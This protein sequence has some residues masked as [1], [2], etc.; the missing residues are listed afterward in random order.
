MCKCLRL[1]LG[2]FGWK[3]EDSIMDLP[4]IEDV[5]EALTEV[6]TIEVS[7]PEATGTGRPQLR[8]A[9]IT[10]INTYQGSPLRGC[11]NDALLMYKVLSEKYDFKTENIDLLTDYD[12]TKANLLKH[13]KKLTYGVQPGD[14]VF[15]HYS[16]HG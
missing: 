12:C 11:V 10:G 3:P 9:L 15:F 8:K 6:E 2:L 13:L 16:G 4:D 14:Y 7:E 1:L 5:Q